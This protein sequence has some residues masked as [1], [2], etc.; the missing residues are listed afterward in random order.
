MEDFISVCLTKNKEL[1]P[2]ASDLLK[3]AFFV[4]SKKEFDD[5]VF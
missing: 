3:H 4:G 1:R 2:K 5:T